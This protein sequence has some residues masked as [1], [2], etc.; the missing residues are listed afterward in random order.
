MLFISLLFYA[1]VVA[2][3]TAVN[4]ASVA[5]AAS[6]GGCLNTPCVEILLIL[7]LHNFLF[8]ECSHFF[9]PIFGVCMCASFSRNTRYKCITL[10]FAT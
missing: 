2:V 3:V 6:A 4:V 10:G 9:P 5:A 8:F 7:L 1:I